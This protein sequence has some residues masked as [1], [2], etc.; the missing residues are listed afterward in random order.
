MGRI[1]GMLINLDTSVPTEAVA[2]EPDEGE[3]V[4]FEELVEFIEDLT[5]VHGYFL[6]ANPVLGV[7][8]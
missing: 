4:S 5:G 8:A 7:G 1:G 6:T 3:D 2:G